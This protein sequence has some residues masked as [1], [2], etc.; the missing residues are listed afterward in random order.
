MALEMLHKIT[1]VKKAWGLMPLLSNICYDLQEPTFYK[2]SL[3]L[4]EYPVLQYVLLE[5]IYIFLLNTLTK[6]FV[7]L[8]TFE[9]H[10]WWNRHVDTTVTC[11]GS[12]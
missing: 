5:I 6:R 10:I 12:S 7:H 4:G 9:Q 2:S 3:L 11:L 1:K 8:L